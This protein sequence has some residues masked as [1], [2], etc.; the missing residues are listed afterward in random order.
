MESESR[1]RRIVFIGGT[2]REFVNFCWERGV[3]PATQ[4]FVGTKYNIL[5]R[6]LC[7]DCAEIVYGVTG[8][9]IHPELLEQ[10][11]CYLAIGPMHG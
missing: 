10:I 2:E 9:P 1:Q 11:R 3:P 7:E 5:G 8:G 6:C 4:I